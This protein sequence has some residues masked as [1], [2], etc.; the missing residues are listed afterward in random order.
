MRNLTDSQVQLHACQGCTVHCMCS[1]R[2][3]CCKSGYKSLVAMHVPNDLQDEF[4]LYM[5][6][7]K[8]GAAAIAESEKRRELQASKA[9]KRADHDHEAHAKIMDCCTIVPPCGGS[10]ARYATG[11]RDGTV[12]LWDCKVSYAQAAGLLSSTQNWHNAM[13]CV[14]VVSQV[15]RLDSN[16]HKNDTA[17]YNHVAL[18]RAVRCGGQRA[19]F[20]A[21]QD[22][23]ERQQLGDSCQ[24]HA[25]V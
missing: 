21:V 12:K 7:E 13:C 19:G 22:H 24:V 3:R 1:A 8:Q 11:A 18:Q 14:W 25:S 16:C 23:S 2:S 9:T 5:L 10:S 15:L 20:V 4:S 6:L 17:Q